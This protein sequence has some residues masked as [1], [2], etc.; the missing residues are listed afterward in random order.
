[1]V[2]LYR[3]NSPQRSGHRGAWLFLWYLNDETCRRIHHHIS[4]DAPAEHI[5]TGI[6]AAPSQALSTS[7]LQS[8]PAN[9]KDV[10]YPLSDPICVL[11]HRHDERFHRASYYHDNHQ[12]LSWLLTMRL[13]GL[14]R[15]P[16]TLSGL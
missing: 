9:S 14:A 2:V 16:N 4:G 7:V 5:R 11:L 8:M 12:G 6:S 1:M 13:G 3:C 15:S 10:Y